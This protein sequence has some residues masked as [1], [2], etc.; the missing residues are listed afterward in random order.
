MPQALREEIEAFVARYP[1]RPGFVKRR[2]DRA[3]PEALARRVPPA[4]KRDERR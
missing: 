4:G 1:D 3:D 2:R